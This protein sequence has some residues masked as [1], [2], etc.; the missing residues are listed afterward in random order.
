MSFDFDIEEFERDVKIKVVG[1]GGGGGNA[2]ANMIRN[3]VEGVEFIAVNTDVAALMKM[4]GNAMERIQIGRKTTK[5]RGAGGKPPV[6]EESAKEN[7][8][9]IAEKLKGA[10]LVFIAA[11]MGGGTGTGAA[12]VVAEIANEMGILTVGVVTKPFDFE[13]EYKMNLAIQGIAELRKHVDTL[14]IVPNQRLLT[15]R[16]KNISMKAAYEMVDDV[17]LQAVKGISD[18]VNGAGFINIDFSDVKATLEKAGDAHMAIGH[19]KGENSAEQAVQE[20]ITSPLLETS[21]KNAG[22]LLV[23]LQISEDTPLEVVN[24]VM[25]LLTEN[26]STEVEVI[27]GVAFGEDLQDEIIVTVIATCFQDDDGK[28][29]VTPDEDIQ[30]VLTGLS[31]ASSSA[32]SAIFPATPISV[33]DFDDD[34]HSDLFEL[35]SNRSK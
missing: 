27:H 7:R 10:T 26:A 13:R 28:A 1:V 6:A 34:D 11:G 14:V 21:I 24:T 15:I 12:P 32:E 29:Y 31:S 19:G 18:L 25:N 9:D 30:E 23:N 22:K 16:E 33:D 17:L 35:L 8:D 4:D 20:I 5:G 3:N 2:V